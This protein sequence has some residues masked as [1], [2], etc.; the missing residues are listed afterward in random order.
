MEKFDYAKNLYHPE[1]DK[2][3]G[4][5]EWWYFDG[6]LH[7]GYSFNIVFSCTNPV[8]MR[9]AQ[10]MA[11]LVKDPA[12]AYNALDYATM[13]VGLMDENRHPIFYGE[14]DLNADQVRIASDRL[15][16]YF[17]EKAHLT[18]RETGGLPDFVID[19][20]IPDGKGKVIKADVVYSPMVQGTT[21]GRGALMDAQTPKGHLYHKWVIPVPNGNVRAAFS[22]T[23]Q[24]GQE[25]VVNQSGNGYHDHNWGNHPLPA[26]L[27]RWYWG[28][29]SEGDL[30][31]IYAVVYNLVP[32]F[33]T[34]KPCLVTFGKD[35]IT[36]T[37]EID[38]IEDKTVTGVQD[39][40]YASEGRIVFKEGSGVKGEIKVSNFK[41]VAEMLCYLRF[42]GDYSMDVEISG[43]KIKR[44]GKT[45]FEYMDLAAA[46]KLK[47]KMAA[48]QK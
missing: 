15:D 46:V 48:R 26:T 10:A 11:A 23:D 12:M 35:I 17:G 36:S 5:Y 30:N 20:E 44:E 42:V 43:G 47:A 19:V 9:Y 4:A 39:L 32:S 7:N 37:E 18:M 24:D 8:G 41:M 33:P 2:M 29:I 22:I 40:T 1:K 38:F 16:V 6:E 3:P 45:M 28:R 31:V 27:E 13:K 21:I 14:L 25:T 34:F